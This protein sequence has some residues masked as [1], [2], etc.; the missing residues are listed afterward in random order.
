MGSA[1]TGNIFGRLPFKHGLAH[2]GPRYAYPFDLEA[3]QGEKS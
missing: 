1:Q 3:A 2:R